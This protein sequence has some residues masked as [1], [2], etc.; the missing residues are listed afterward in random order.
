LTPWT[1]AALIPVV[2]ALPSGVLLVIEGETVVWRA[3]RAIRASAERALESGRNPGEGIDAFAGRCS[4]RGA[5]AACEKRKQIGE[6]GDGS[7]ME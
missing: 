7:R 1:A 5:I 6:I 2:E 4:D 3:A